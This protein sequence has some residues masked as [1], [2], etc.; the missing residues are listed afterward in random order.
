M[1]ADFLSS[2]DEVSIRGVPDFSK[3][4]VVGLKILS[5]RPGSFYEAIGLDRGDT[6]LELNGRE[7][8]VKSGFEAFN[9]L[10]KKGK[11]TVKVLRGCDPI[12]IQIN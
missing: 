10:A 3:G 12:L 4:K 11:G 5:I 7:L 2:P 9:G 6:L 1:M 8:E